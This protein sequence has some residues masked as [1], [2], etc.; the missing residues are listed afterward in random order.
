MFYVSFF[1]IYFLLYFPFLIF[2]F[3]F[4]FFIFFFLVFVSIFLLFLFCFFLLSSVCVIF[5]LHHN[6]SL[7]KQVSVLNHLYLDLIS[8][9]FGP[10]QFNYGFI[11]I[12]ISLLYGFYLYHLY[13]VFCC[14][15]SLTFCCLYFFFFILCYRIFPILMIPYDYMFPGAFFC[16][17]TF[18]IN[19]MCYI[20]RNLS[21]F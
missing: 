4:F 5:V 9:P 3:F 10:F 12:M 6:F 16:M 7:S 15:T 2:V 13:L 17:S 21:F 1:F 14:I 8:I 19:I 18:R 20:S 11:S